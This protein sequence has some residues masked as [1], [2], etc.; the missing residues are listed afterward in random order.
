MISKT[1]ILSVKPHKACIFLF[2]LFDTLNN[3]EYKSWNTEWDVVETTKLIC[4][5]IFNET[6]YN[7]DSHKLI[8]RFSF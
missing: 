2:D 6:F 1:S 7:A 4:N 5:Y 3:I 8:W